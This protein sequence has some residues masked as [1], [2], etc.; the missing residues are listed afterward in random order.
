[1]AQNFE[2][3]PRFILY[4]PFYIL[5]ML[6][7]PF[8]IR[9]I[10]NNLPL[11]FISTLVFVICYFIP[12]PS[13]WMFNVLYSIRIL[14]GLIIIFCISHSC[15]S[16]INHSSKYL[17]WLGAAAYLS[18]AAYMFH[19]QIIIIFYHLWWPADKFLLAVYFF[20]VIFPVIFL[21]SYFIQSSYDKLLAKITSH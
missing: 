14:A 4:Y 19:R 17:K 5:G 9:K 2:I 21:L 3:D 15:A 1:M 16:F 11:A 6:T 8:I 7:P 18:M 10:C 20:T 13:G 12:E